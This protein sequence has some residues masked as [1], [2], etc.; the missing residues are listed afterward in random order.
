MKKIINK[1]KDYP[2]LRNRPILKE[3]IKFSLVGS[4]NTFLDFSIYFSLTRLFPFWRENYLGANFI[5]FIIAATSSYILNKTWTFRDK[6]KK[7]HIQYPKFLLVST[8][9]L[10]LN[11]TIL[12]LLVSQV[13]IHDLLAKLIAVGV[14]MMWNFSLNKFWTFKTDKNNENQ[15]LSDS[16]I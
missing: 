10:I 3:I 11:E 15:R 16:E 5:S 12:Y 7:I 14:V 13:K 8:I 9:G 1:I 4:F 2:Q 6:N